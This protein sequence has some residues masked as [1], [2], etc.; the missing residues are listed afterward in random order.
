MLPK[1][2][3]AAGPFAI[4]TVDS[5]SRQRIKLLNRLL[6]NTTLSPEKRLVVKDSSQPFMRL[7]H[8]EVDQFPMQV[9]SISLHDARFYHWAV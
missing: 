5:V 6:A 2:M 3:G 1:A 7:S 8:W 9:I 4:N